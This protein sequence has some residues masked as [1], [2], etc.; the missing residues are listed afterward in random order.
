[1]ILAQAIAAAPHQQLL[2]KNFGQ[3]SLVKVVDAA[4]RQLP[5]PESITR[6]LDAL[7]SAKK[8]LIILGKGAA[9]AQVDQ[10]IKDFVEKSGVPYLPMSMA[11]GLLPCS[12]AGKAHPIF[13]QNP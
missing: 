9:Y 6:A 12:L 8:P 13:Q 10:I 5:A 2:P 4:P 1:M 11:K 7:K 3:S